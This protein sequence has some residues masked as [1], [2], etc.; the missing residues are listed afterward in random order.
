VIEVNTIL[1]QD[2]SNCDSTC[3]VHVIHLQ[4]FKRNMYFSTYIHGLQKWYEKIYADAMCTSENTHCCLTSTG[5]SSTHKPSNSAQT[6]ILESSW[7]FSV[8]VRCP[9]ARLMM[10]GRLPLKSYDLDF[11]QYSSVHVWCV[12]NPTVRCP[13]DVTL[14]SMT[15]QNFVRMPWNCKKYLIFTRA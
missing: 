2:C 5:G 12:E 6:V 8:I 9:T 14:P 11:K 4:L 7:R 10:P 13:A 15:L 1:A 3:L